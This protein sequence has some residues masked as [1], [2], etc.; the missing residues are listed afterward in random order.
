MDQ[1]MVDGLMARWTTEKCMYQ[2]IVLKQT[3]QDYK[4]VAINYKVF[5]I[6]SKL[7]L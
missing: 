7:E 6:I 4:V 2:H 5:T 3:K 1:W